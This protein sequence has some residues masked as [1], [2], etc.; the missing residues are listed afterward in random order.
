MAM[1]TGRRYAD[2]VAQYERGMLS[3]EQLIS[4]RVCKENV[5]LKTSLEDVK[6]TRMKYRNYIKKEAI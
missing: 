4:V 6:S 3:I 5:H 1:E 2:P